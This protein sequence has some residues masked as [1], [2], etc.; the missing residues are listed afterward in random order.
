MMF[1]S[2]LYGHGL[3]FVD[4]PVIHDGEDAEELKERF[5]NLP[6]KL[7][8]VVLAKIHE[9]LLPFE[10]RILR[11]VCRAFYLTI[12]LVGAKRVNLNA[13]HCDFVYRAE[14][15]MK[16]TF[17]WWGSQASEFQLIGAVGEASWL[18]FLRKRF[19]TVLVRKHSQLLVAEGEDKGTDVESESA[20]R[21]VLK[22]ALHDDWVIVPGDDPQAKRPLRINV[23]KNSLLEGVARH[24]SADTDLILTLPSALTTFETDKSAA[25]QLRKL[26]DS[27][28]TIVELRNC[29][30][31]GDK[32]GAALRA[33]AGLPAL[34]GLH[35]LRLPKTL[36]ESLAFLS[37]R[38]LTIVDSE[39]PSVAFA[40]AAC[41][42]QLLEL[43]CV[44]PPP[45]TVSQLARCF[46]SLEVLFLDLRALSS[47]EEAEELASA[48]SRCHRM[49]QV[50]VHTNLALF[51]ADI[52][53]RFDPAFGKPLGRPYL[54]AALTH[55]F[56]CNFVSPHLRFLTLHIQTDSAS[57]IYALSGNTVGLQGLQSIELRG[58]GVTDDGVMAL[59]R[60]SVSLTSLDL[61]GCPTVSTK[62]V[63]RG[64]SMLGCK[65]RELMVDKV[66]SG[67]LDDLYGH[68]PWVSVW[69]DCG[70][71]RWQNPR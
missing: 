35:V 40:L 52:T 9:N 1:S 3:P 28:R 58:K 50:G 27:C 53:G 13:L 44:A 42:P 68:C 31:R 48:L 26:V 64:I 70:N 47:E 32:D 34:R 15:R 45:E 23:R 21:Q 7:S 71:G 4:L 30:L 22:P 65:L 69:V 14:V 2:S 66:A 20:L 33:L 24:C 56:L 37:V 54:A 41:C 51:R 16:G 39:R 36:P 17:S 63:D 67:T 38:K 5:S 8:P 12:P 60:S 49:R 59:C 19:P 46:T 6:S 62:A 11:I 55:A 10:R 25:A 61:T 43:S 57:P 29:L 18:P